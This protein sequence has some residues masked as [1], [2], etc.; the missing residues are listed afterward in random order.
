LSTVLTRHPN[1]SSRKDIRLIRLRM[2]GIE[3]FQLRAFGI[4]S[5]RFRA[6]GIEELQFLT[7]GIEK[8]QFRTLGIEIVI[9]WLCKGLIKSRVGI[10]LNT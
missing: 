10:S 6:F 8:L 5:V 4:E 7:L 1:K 2:F 9:S 3:E